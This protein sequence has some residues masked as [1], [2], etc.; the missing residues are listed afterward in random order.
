MEPLTYNFADPTAA[1][2]NGL[3]LGA[4]QQEIQQRNQAQ[5]IALQQQVQQQADLHALAINPN[6]THADYSRVM[7]QYP[8]LA[9]NL[10]KSFKV[11]NEGQQQNLLNFTSRVYSAQTAGNNDLAIKLLR[12]RAAADPAQADHYNTLADLV[13]QSPSTA[14]TTTAMMLA[15]ALGPEKFATTYSNLGTEARADQKQPLEVKKLGGEAA[16]AVAKGDVAPQVQSLEVAKKT[17]EAQEALV[18]GGNA[19]AAAALGNQ[20][21]QEEIL[22]AQAQRQVASFNAQI[23]ASNSETERGRLTLA[24]DEFIAK[25]QL[26]NNQVAQD[27]QGHFDNLTQ[28]LSLVRGL[29]G[30][31]DNWFNFNRV[32]SLEGKLLS[33]IPGTDA[34]DF[35]A[36]LDTLKS[37]QF[38]AQAKEMKGMGA[39]SDA[40]GA[41]IERA[42]ASLD[43][44]QSPQ[45]FKNALGVIEATLAKG[46]AKLIANGKLPTSGGAFVMRHPQFGNVTD[47]DIQ[48]L[49]AQNPG[50]TRD[51]VIQF[52]RST[53]GK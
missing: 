19:A 12:D 43:P 14:R 40:E 37:Q 16:D 3:K 6:A 7:T 30:D 10:G 53:G 5:Q 11:L 48:R 34:K 2:G 31:L 20:K 29:K 32:G 45:A 24:R 52:L 41:R 47:G 49:M 39:L 28:S 46:Q 26:Q 33:F 51:Q 18:K 50:S 13:E 4:V 9:E 42:V 23:A 27:A 35:R 21:T 22:S 25:Q 17:G 44:D 8:Q 36:K 38:L 1:I 15:G